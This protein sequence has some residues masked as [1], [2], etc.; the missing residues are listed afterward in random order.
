MEINE[1]T[2]SWKIKWENPKIP[3]NFFKTLSTVLGEGLNNW[4]NVAGL[5]ILSQIK[6]LNTFKSIL[7]IN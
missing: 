6:N 3:R 5:S 1:L 4:K 7:L 2:S